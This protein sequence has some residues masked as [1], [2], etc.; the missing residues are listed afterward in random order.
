MQEDWWE[1]KHDGLKFRSL[2]TE[3]PE[4]SNHSVYQVSA[5]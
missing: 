2:E 5:D 4:P 3:V 1:R